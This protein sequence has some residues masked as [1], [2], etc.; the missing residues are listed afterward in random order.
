VSEP[1]I[2]LTA[3]FSEHD[4]VGRR[5]VADALI[6]VYERHRIRTSVL[7]R[8]AEGFGH[9]SR[10]TDRMLTLSEAL[11]LASV[12]VDQR[13]RVEAAL[14]EVSQLVRHGVV[15]LERAQLLSGD[16]LE[17]PFVPDQARPGSVKL[18]LYGGRSV[19]AGGRS[20]YVEAID[21]LR[22]SGAVAASVLLAVDGTLHGERRRARFFARNA[23]VP[24]M[25][26]AVGEAGPLCG[27]IPELT[28][29]LD[30]PVATVERVQVC[31]IAGESLS[32]PARVRALDSS[33]LSIWQKLMVHVDE[34]AR[35]GSQPLYRELIRR[36][37]G[38]GGVGATALRGVRGFYAD[39]EP[40]FDRFL[41]LRRHAPVVVV[42]ID[43]PEN[44][45]VLW[46][47]VD[48]VTSHSGV[49]TSELV[50]ASTGLGGDRDGRLALARTP[51]AEQLSCAWRADAA[52]RRPRPR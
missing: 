22:R 29:L 15:M 14:P 51:A 43:T 34:Q 2:K 46:P 3:Y 5:F 35:S 33:G 48:E 45:S 17:R 4:R 31:K 13:A 20:G 28:G 9:R 30:G 23:S 52:P 40:L 12:A 21:R 16:E 42:M 37:H 49:V 18:S 27:A 1:A 41:S 26:M 50:P 47:I 25:L 6:D 24:L 11:P 7:L 10:L 19:R 39:R 32:E 36:V 8:G 44:V 38:A